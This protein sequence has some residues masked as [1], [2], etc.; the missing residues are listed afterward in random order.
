MITY[1]PD[2][3]L[4][5]S[6]L[7]V[8]TTGSLSGAARSLRSTQPTVGRHIDELESR[9]KTPLFTRSQAGLEP[10]TVA[11]Q[12]AEHARTMAAAAAALVRVASG[13][14]E[15]T[16]GT[17]RITASEVVGAEVLPLV[18]GSFRDRYPETEIE[19]VLS[20]E[21]QD[22][23]RREVDIAVRMVRPTQTG[24]VARKIGETT[25]GLHAHARYLATNSSPATMSDLDRHTVIGFDQDTV[26]IQALKALG[27]SVHRDAFA[28]RTDSDLAQLAMIRAGI[29]IGGCQV[30]IARRSSELVRVLS[31]DF[32]INLPVWIAMHEDLRA[33]RR[34][35]AMFD[36]LVAELP[37]LFE[38]SP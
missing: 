18:L 33:V 10:T 17:I 35:R 34:M 36:H 27:L 23:L 25:I 7:A 1:D 21:T 5:R 9:L 20:N 30:G 2:W 24:L 6:F 3:N 12:L 32:A 4:W 28:V 11:L 8:L 22:L 19:L 26:S 38:A 16:Q 13:E 15:S 31:D 14:A 29:G 37:A